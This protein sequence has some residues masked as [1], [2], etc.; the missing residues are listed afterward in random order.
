M[1][2]F[3]T[4]IL[5]TLTGGK[6]FVLATILTRRGSAPRTPG[7]RMM[8][9]SDGRIQGTIGGG[10]IEADVI[11]ASTDLLARPE[12]PPCLIREF[13]LNNTITSGL[14]M[15]CGGEIR[16]WLERII[17]ANAHELAG[18]YNALAEMKARG[19]KGCLI[20]ALSGPSTREFSTRKHLVKADGSL[21]WGPELD[22]LP[23]GLLSPQA[24][25][26]SIET[27]GLEEYIIEPVVPGRRLHIFGAGHV[28]FHLAAI[29]ASLEMDH[30]VVDDRAEF[31]NAQRFPHAA[32]VLCPADFRSAF[33]SLA[34]NR[35]SDVV[36]LTRGHLHD[37]MVLAEVL[38][39]PAGYIG[40]IGSRRKRDTIYRNLATKGVA[41]ADLT[42]VFSPVGLAIGAETP[43]EIAVSIMAEL[44]QYRANL[45]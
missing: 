7:T 39:T 6:P 23:T 41:K 28:G 20:S 32:A 1:K 38:K 36:I 31:A 37:E 34:L 11:R 40:M 29:A 19:E 3:E 13:I 24:G 8:V 4:E 10:Q 22:T 42:R 5:T 30:V 33:A 15:V 18:L 27:R 12:A 26:I 35:H 43:G 14:D 21:A 17:P 2:N 45:S 25:H 44:I 9:Y 16:V